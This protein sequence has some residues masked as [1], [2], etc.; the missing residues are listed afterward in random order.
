MSG[1]ILA[2]IAVVAPPL[3]TGTRTIA[4]VV[5][6]LAAYEPGYYVCLAAAGLIAIAGVC[7]A[8]DD[9]QDEREPQTGAEF[10]V[11]GRLAS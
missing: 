8:V 3:S 5:P 1:W 9:A 4:P 6:H 2:G 7:G 11:S 10:G